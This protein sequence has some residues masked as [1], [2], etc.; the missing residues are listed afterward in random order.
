MAA[1]DDTLNHLVAWGEARD[2]VRAMLL[3]ST[4]AAPGGEVDALSDYDVIL[5]VRDIRP[6]AHERRWL[7][8]FG[9]VLVAYWDPVAPDPETGVDATGNVVQ[10]ADGLKIDFTGATPSGGSLRTNA[11]ETG[12][13]GRGP[14]GIPSCIAFLRWSPTRRATFGPMRS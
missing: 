7:A 1:H 13:V 9:E 5:V 11:E 12:G 8:D 2:D 4:R 3:T 10:Y 14:S 6:Y